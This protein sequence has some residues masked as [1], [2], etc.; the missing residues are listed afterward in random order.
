MIFPCYE[1]ET[2]MYPTV[3]S[4]YCVVVFVAVLGSEFAEQ[5]RSTEAVSGE[6]ITLDCV[7]PRGEPAPR[8]RWTKDNNPLKPDAHRVNVLQSGGL[9]IRDVSRHDAGS[10]ACIAYNIGGERESGAAKL[11]VR[12][13]WRP[14]SNDTTL[15]FCL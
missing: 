9:R 8:V 4:G 6:D 12:G 11:I 7:P 14:K 15:N 3:L 5:P 1:T 10:Y 2:C 13:E